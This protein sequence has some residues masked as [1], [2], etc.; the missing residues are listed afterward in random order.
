M[1]GLVPRRGK[2][3]AKERA[4]ASGGNKYYVVERYGKLA[5]EKTSW[6][7]GRTSVGS[8]HDLDEALALIKADSGS[9]KIETR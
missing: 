1:L 8:A 5:V 7:P 9:S 4:Y 2:P 6:W 3:L